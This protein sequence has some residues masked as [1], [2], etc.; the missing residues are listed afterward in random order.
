M[1]IKTLQIGH[2]AKTWCNKELPLQ[3]LKSQAGFYIGT[4]GDDGPCS[5]E[6]SEYFS[7]AAKAQAALDDGS[8]TQKET[9]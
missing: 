8:W 3:V 5:R 1:S 4:A 7:T 2:L 6:S 9:P